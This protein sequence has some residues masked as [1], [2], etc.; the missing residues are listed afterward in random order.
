MRQSKGLLSERFTGRAN[1]APIKEKK[2]REH[3]IIPLK[4]QKEKRIVEERFT[5]ED[6][7][8]LELSYE[9]AETKSRK[10]EQVTGQLIRALQ[11]LLIIASVYMTYLIYGVFVTSYSYDAS[12]QVVPNIMSVSELQ[13]IAE[14]D[15]LQ[16]Y[17]LRA[18]N[19]YKETLEL[20]YKLSQNE[21]NALLIAMEYQELLKTVDKLV[22]D[23]SAE[24][25]NGKYS[26]VY[27]QMRTWI[28]TDIAVY[29]QNIS[30]A[31]TENSEDKA[32][33]ALIARG[34]MYD[35]FARITDN[36]VT[37]ARSI[38][39]VY[40]GDTYSWSPDEYSKSLGAKVSE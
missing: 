37:I 6:E 10:R 33:K 5:E 25:V 12:G 13:E 20:D 15:V 24:D 34:I 2:I 11:I 31:I 18:Q 22:T 9:T 1:D 39:G 26:A 21:D 32:N 17:Y 7:K 28:A 30:A 38:K 36:M 23:L 3:N 40:I 27:A 29:L 14:Y 35:D 19:L 8:E 4:K 16:S